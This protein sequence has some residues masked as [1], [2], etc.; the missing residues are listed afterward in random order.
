MKWLSKLFSK[1]EKEQ[2]FPIPKMY[3][4]EEMT[5]LEAHIAQHFGNFDNVFHE[6][7]SF[8]IHVD[9]AIIEPTDERNYYTLVTMGM[10]AH[11]MNVPKEL[12]GY[13]LDRAELMIC[14]PPNWKVHSDL[15]IVRDEESENDPNSPAHENWYWPTRWLKNLARLPINADTWLGYGHTIPNGPE[16]DPFAENTKLG[17]I[18]LIPPLQFNE[19][20]QM[21]QMPDGSRVVFYQMLPLHAD[22]MNYKLANDADI[23]LDKFAK[24]TVMEDVLTLNINRPSILNNHT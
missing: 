11:K 17:C 5:V 3:T 22:E 10:G 15:E 4:E 13:Q 9:I 19:Q 7:L 20:A 24:H 16:V 21:C 23:L 2:E 18:M 1:K 12:A 8:D 6:I 14:L